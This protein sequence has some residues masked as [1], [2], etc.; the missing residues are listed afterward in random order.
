MSVYKF[1][2]AFEED[3]NIFRDIEIKPSQTM[4][5]LN[6]IIISS[7]SLPEKSSKQLFRSND[8]W[9]KQEQMD[10][11]PKAIKK[12][13]NV[14][15]PMLINFIDDPHQRFLY[16]FEA[17]KQAF[18]LLIE[19]ININ[20]VEKAGEIY[21]KVSKSA[22]PSPVRKEDLMAHLSKKVEGEDDVV[23]GVDAE[24]GDIEGMGE[25]GEEVL[26]GEPEE[27]TADDNNDE[28]GG[29]FD[30]E[31]GAEDFKE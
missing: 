17:P 25:E 2:V 19:L 27:E 5:D 9:H 31:A 26:E 7:F 28:F 15:M 14:M 18:S 23:Y 29:E 20:T 4:K 12:G 30:F 24:E 3:E 21:P 10:L 11:N 1:R 13:K 8:N 16:E 22:G 6:E